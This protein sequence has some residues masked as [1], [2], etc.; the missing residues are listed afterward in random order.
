MST[1]NIHASCILLG[2]AGARFGAPPDAAILLL[3]ESGAGKSTVA[4]QLLARGA[5]LVA[6]DRAELF[7]RDDQLWARAPDN[8]AG[9]IEV[10]GVG[11]VT[12]PYAANARV[13]L[14][15]RLVGRDRVSRYPEPLTFEVAL[16][17]ESFPPL[18]LL[19]ADDISVA[20]RIVL[21]AAA[22]ANA[23]FR[24]QCNSGEGLP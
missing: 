5:K 10:R 24:E 13:L 18:I 12:L 20:D 22:H 3:G 9:L 1:L 8:L 21:A 19:S 4:L 14:A 16:A 11:I 2:D 15:I 23:L 6:D 17:V 7:V